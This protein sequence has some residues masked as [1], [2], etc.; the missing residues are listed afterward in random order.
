MTFQSNESGLFSGS[1]TSQFP[2]KSA[3]VLVATS[4]M[5]PTNGVLTISN[6]S[7]SEFHKMSIPSMFKLT[8]LGK[9]IMYTNSTNRTSSHPRAIA[10]DNNTVILQT[11]VSSSMSHQPTV[12][13]QAPPPT[14]SQVVE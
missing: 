11:A 13:V 6:E 8:F 4:T 10:V 9:D 7:S 14:T 3:K 12:I 1:A 2:S 5:M